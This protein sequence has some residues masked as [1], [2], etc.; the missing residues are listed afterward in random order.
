MTKYNYVRKRMVLTLCIF[1]IKKVRLQMKRWLPLLIATMILADVMPIS[2]YAAEQEHLL[3]SNS[4]SSETEISE[5]SG[6]KIDESPESEEVEL[7]ETGAN[8][9]SEPEGTE[10]RQIEALEELEE[11]IDLV[12]SEEKSDVKLT[13]DQARPDGIKTIE[14]VEYDMVYV[15][16]LYEGLIQASDLVMPEESGVITYADTVYASVEEAGEEFRLKMK[17]KQPDIVINFRVDSFDESIIKGYA[18]QIVSNAVQHTGEPSEGDYL[19]WQYGGYRCS[20][21]VSKNLATFIYTVT[22]YTTSEQEQEV[23]AEIA[24]LIDWL[25]LNDRSDYEKIQKIYDWICDN[26]KYDHVHMGDSTYLSQFTAYAALVDKTAVCQGYTVLFYRLAMEVGIDTRVISGLGNGGAHGW[27]IVKLNNRYYNLDATWDAGVNVYRYFLKSNADFGN[28]VRDLEYEED[29]FN[30]NYPMAAQTYTS[31]ETKDPIEEE[32]PEDTNKPIEVVPIEPSYNGL[33]YDSKS[34]NWFW[35]KNGVIDTSYYNVV[36]YGDF[37]WCVREGKLDFGYTGLA[38]NS[39]GWWY[40]DK[41]KVNFGYN[42]VV[43]YNGSWWYIKNGKLDFG[44]TGLAQNSNGWWYIRKGAVDWN[45]S[46]KVR[47]MGKDYSVVKGKVIH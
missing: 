5:F 19:R 39:N 14:D 7:I 40:I 26:V 36:P 46:G 11:N 9:T 15:N 45:Y 35:Y 3:E 37:W 47:Y 34:G 44:Y 16:P 4:E 27:N 30:A 41:G 43:L 21:K 31:V 38:Q 25:N 8:E 29:T 12:I 28:H 33:K 13:E 17:E 1:E 18:T 24:S 10:S 6:A 23:D 20:M 32:K 2:V 42:S 22:Y